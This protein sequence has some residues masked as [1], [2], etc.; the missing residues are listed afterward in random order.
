MDAA[1]RN[2]LDTAPAALK[3]QMA[4]TIKTVIN[5]LN[6]QLKGTFTVMSSSS[7]VLTH[8]LDDPQALAGD[9]YQLCF[10]KNR[11]GYEEEVTLK[12]ENARKELHQGLIAIQEKAIKPGDKGYFFKAMDDIYRAALEEKPGRGNDMHFHTL[13]HIH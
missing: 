11:V 13:L 12:V 6:R 2:V 4:Q 5:D 1:F 8:V 7:F 3:A 10:G 9:A